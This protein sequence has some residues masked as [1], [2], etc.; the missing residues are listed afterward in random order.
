MISA[1]TRL[2]RKLAGLCRCGRHAPEDRNLCDHCDAVHIA[3]QRRRRGP[4]TKRGAYR[5]GECWRT[6][7]NRQ[8]CPEIR[9]AA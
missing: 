4:P 7:H 9:R 6:G 2:S 3:W 5:C 8:R 1:A